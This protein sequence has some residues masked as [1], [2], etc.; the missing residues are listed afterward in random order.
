MVERYVPEKDRFEVQFNCNGKVEAKA[1]KAENLLLLTQAEAVAVMRNE[2]TT[3]D[4]PTAVARLI[5]VRLRSMQLVPEVLRT[6]KVGRIVSEFGK[7]TNDTE[8]SRH[9]RTL[10]DTWKQTWRQHMA[11]E[12]AKSA[13]KPASEADGQRAKVEIAREEHSQPSALRSQPRRQPSQ[14]PRWDAEHLVDLLKQAK[15]DKEISGLLQELA[16]SRCSDAYRSA[17]VANNGL[18]VLRKWI[19]KRPGVRRECMDVL[20]VITLTSK[21][22][23]EEQLQ[24][25]L[26]DIQDFRPHVQRQA[27]SLLEAWRNAG[28][29]PKVAE[30]KMT[31]EGEPA[32]KRPR[33]EE[34]DVEVEV[35]EETSED[36][37][38][39][40]AVELDALSAQ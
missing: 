9:C 38:M 30:G 29:L 10:V 28:H 32:T 23:E 8:L 11:S 5:I 37:P 34:E 3:P 39:F 21:Q 17:F 1:V 25:V 31:A 6:T 19:R 22:I 26:M 14:P 20:E 7:Q 15:D 27:S 40:S 35:K 36:L 18:K 4:L 16:S 33:M 24:D 13:T 2:L 12:E